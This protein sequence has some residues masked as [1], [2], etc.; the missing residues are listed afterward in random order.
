VRQA[1]LYGDETVAGWPR[2]A[3]SRLASEALRH[4]VA[5]RVLR[6]V[7]DDGGN[8][9][10]GL[11]RQPVTV[12]RARELVAQ[13]KPHTVLDDDYLRELAKVYREAESSGRPTVAVRQRWGLSRDTAPKHVAQA[14]ARTDP[15]TGKP[16]LPPAAPRK[17]R[18]SK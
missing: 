1:T 18:S 10:G 11:S 2:L 6:P 13:R 7:V 12:R 17:R 9:V 5:E 14:R 15:Q 3:L 8:V 4:Y 16:F